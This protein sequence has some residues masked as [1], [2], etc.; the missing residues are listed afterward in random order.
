MS[1]KI[2]ARATVTADTTTLEQQG[3]IRGG[4][5]LVANVAEKITK[6]GFGFAKEVQ[7]EVS[8]RLDG[9]LDFIETTQHGVIR[10]VRSAN[11]RIG[12]GLGEVIVAAESLSLGVIRLVSGVA[13]SA[14]HVV[15][16][17]AESISG[18]AVREAA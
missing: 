16:R 10:V 14:T 17:T 5:A 4:V 18:P 7:G 11:N 12:N 8:A 15:A 2:A 13:K 1:E 6:D 9:G 3:L